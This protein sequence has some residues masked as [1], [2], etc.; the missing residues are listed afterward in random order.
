MIKKGVVNLPVIILYILFILT[1]FLAIFVFLSLKGPDYSD[2]YMEKLLTE[3]IKNP[4]FSE[5]KIGFE[6]T[7]NSD[8]KEEASEEEFIEYF[9]TIIEAY[10][11]HAPPF[12]SET[13]KIQFNLDN[14]DYNVEILKG[15]IY[16][17]EG[18]INNKDIIIGST[19]EELKKIFL[20]EDYLQE[21]F[22]SG[23]SSIE[24]VASVTKLWI[25]GYTKIYSKI[26]GGKLE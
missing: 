4:V 2:I 17:D 23:M 7:N 8:N 15:K 6:D 20:N 12:S 3:E 5:P 26:T 16:V 22:T 14:K 18:S 19:K 1:I 24:L 9:M 11:L 21:S 10:N 25:K 13:P